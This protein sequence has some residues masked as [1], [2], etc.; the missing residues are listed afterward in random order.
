[1]VGA[2]SA[3]VTS[4]SNGGDDQD[5]GTFPGFYLEFNFARR[6]D[7]QLLTHKKNARFPISGL[8]AAQPLVLA[9]EHGSAVQ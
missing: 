8:A 2:R 3:I 6:D 5:T 7:I 4:A 1:M 9:I